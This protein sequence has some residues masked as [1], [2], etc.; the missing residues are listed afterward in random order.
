MAYPT[1]GT[2]VNTD[3]GSSVTSMSVN[4]PATVDAGDL[5]LTFV[6]VRN[7][8]T[9]NTIPTNWNKITEQAGGGSVG[10]TSIFYK[11][12]DGT[13]DGGT[14]TW[15]AS[16]LT[17]AAWQTMRITTW[18]GTTVPEV[19][20]ASSGDSSSA[21]PPTLTPSW[22]S[23]ETL[24]IVVAGHTAASAAAFTAAPTNYITF[25]N[26]GASSGGSACSIASATRQLTATSEDP[27]TFTAGGSNRWW[28]AQTIAI[29]PAAVGGSQIKTVGGLAIASVKTVGGL[30][31]ASVKTIGG[32][33]NQ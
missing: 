9:W 5:L 26:N 18:H 33:T 23:A 3:F 1:P 16:A 2:Q 21:N 14:A 22:G 15:V 29:R 31:V 32:L 19:G 24:W 8:I 4:M 17:T 7:A 20:T 28:A 12:A 11:I 30:A 13:E 6:V 27:G 10:E 25:A